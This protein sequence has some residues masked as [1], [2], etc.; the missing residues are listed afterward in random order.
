M[1]IFFLKVEPWAKD[2]PYALIKVKFRSLEC[3][4][5]QAPKF[6]APQAPKVLGTTST[7]SLAS[8]LILSRITK[9]G[10]IFL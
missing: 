9:D 2:L 7:Q 3:L 8:H 6:L 5:P 4:A 10:E 1:R